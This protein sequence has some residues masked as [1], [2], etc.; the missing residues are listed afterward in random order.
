MPLVN[1]SWWL[2]KSFNSK[3]SQVANC[4]SIKSGVK[5]ANEN[6]WNSKRAGSSFKVSILIWDI[7]SNRKK[8]TW[9]QIDYINTS[10]LKYDFLQHSWSCHDSWFKFFSM[11]LVFRKHGFK[12][13]DTKARIM[14]W[15]KHYFLHFYSRQL[16]LTQ[17]TRLIWSQSFSAK[18]ILSERRNQFLGSL[19]G[20]RLK[21]KHNVRKQEPLMAICFFLLLARK[22]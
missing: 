10:Q 7:L 3:V 1:R 12:K 9:F 8:Q 2:Q 5:K 4:S 13:S 20:A 16:F 15:N 18:V 19:P 17:V 21:V 11:K 6:F 22:L 14:I